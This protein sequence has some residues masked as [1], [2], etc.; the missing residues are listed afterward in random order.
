MSLSDL[1]TQEKDDFF[2]LISGTI[3]EK[4]EPLVALFTEDSSWIRKI[5]ENFKAKQTA[6]AGK[7]KAAWEEIL[8]GE[9]TI[10]KGMVDKE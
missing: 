1:S 5:S 4:L 3:D 2:V 7:N 10:L 6:F 8:K 9:E